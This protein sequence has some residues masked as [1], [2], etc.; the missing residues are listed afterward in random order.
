MRARNRAPRQRQPARQKTDDPLAPGVLPGTQHRAQVLLRLAIVGQDGQQRQVAPG[1]VVALKTD[2]CWSRSAR[3]PFRQRP[4]RRDRVRRSRSGRHHGARP[5]RPPFPLHPARHEP[6]RN[7]AARDGRGPP[8][9]NFAGMTVFSSTFWRQR[10]CR[11]PRDR[12]HRRLIAT[13]RRDVHTARGVLPLHTSPDERPSPV[14][15]KLMAR[16]CTESG[17]QMTGDRRCSRS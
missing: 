15:V 17:S 16:R 11:H 10:G 7:D 13:Q 5:G 2:T 8:E 1:I 12:D 9:Y 4:G 6:D 14:I 3:L